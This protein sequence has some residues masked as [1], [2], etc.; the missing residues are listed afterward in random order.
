[1]QTNLENIV[2]AAAL[3]LPVVLYFFMMRLTNSS[4]TRLGKYVDESGKTRDENFSKQFGTLIRNVSPRVVYCNGSSDVVREATSLIEQALEKFRRG[5]T[6]LAQS[7]AGKND[8]KS[9]NASNEKKGADYRTEDFITIYGSTTL[10]EQDTGSSQHEQAKDDTSERYAGALRKAM[11]A[12]IRFRRYVNLLKPEDLIGRSEKVRVQYASWLGRQYDELVSSTTSELIDNIRAPRWGTANTS[13]LTNEGILE[14]KAG[15]NT[16]LAV[17]DP[18]I[19]ATMRS[20][21]REEIENADAK[22]N[23]AYA[24]HIPES[25]EKLMTL[26]LDVCSEVG[27]DVADISTRIGDRPGINPS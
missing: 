18:V 10:G 9:D 24:A 19:A 16:A 8:S 7:N 4:V 6:N 20:S 14:I 25:I 27:L 12:G 17:F 23:L 5:R 13:F 22:N 3:A 1:M 21:M 26:V 11:H 2:I 15:G